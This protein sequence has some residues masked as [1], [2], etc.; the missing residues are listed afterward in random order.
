MSGDILIGIGLA[1]GLVGGL[2]FLIYTIEMAYYNGATDGYGFAKEPNN[3]GYKKA[4]RYLLRW[5]RHRWPELAHI[6]P[7]YDPVDDQVLKDEDGPQN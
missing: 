3:P 7:T 1:V 2:G 6:K 4:G 5:M